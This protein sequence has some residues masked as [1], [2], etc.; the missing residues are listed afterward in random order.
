VLYAAAIFLFSSMS[1]PPS[2]PGELS[3]KHQH[4]LAY[5]GLSLLLVRALAGGTWRGVS[6]KV[7]LV[8]AALAALYGA[9]DELHQGFVPGRHP[10]ALDLAADA[11]GAT[12]GAALAFGWRRIVSRRAGARI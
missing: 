2:A 5:A 12:A 3:D 7:C 4:G 9:G 8:A 11:A 6:A 1:A 10:D